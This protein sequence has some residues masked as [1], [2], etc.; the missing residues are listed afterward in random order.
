[1]GDAVLGGSIAV[2]TVRIGGASAKVNLGIAR[3]ADFPIL[4]RA[5]VIVDGVLG[6]ALDENGRNAFLD[7]FRH[8]IDMPLF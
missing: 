2:E 1:M 4:S 5:G 7:A 6:L 3:L 8:S